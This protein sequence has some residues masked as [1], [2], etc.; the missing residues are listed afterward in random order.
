MRQVQNCYLCGSTDNLT[1]DH[2]P[3]ESFFP[4][5]LPTNLIT[6]RCCKK[7]NND[8][9]LDDEAFLVWITSAPAINEKGLWI[10]RNKIGPKLRKKKKLRENVRKHVKIATVNLPSGPAQ[11]PLS[12]FPEERGDRF[13]IRLT[14]GLIRHFYPHYDYSMDKFEV[15]CVKPFNTIEWGPVRNLVQ[16]LPHDSRGDGVFDFWHR[17][18]E[19]EDLGAWMFCFY[20]AAV[21]IVW[22]T[23]NDI[24]LPRETAA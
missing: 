2:I 10:L 4:S 11:L 3:P 7:C 21:L 1:K 13:M 8:F 12:H 20:Q 23:R 16:K 9:S 22:Q 18:P 5:P 6:V 15:Q 14:K 17:L 24:N 19:A